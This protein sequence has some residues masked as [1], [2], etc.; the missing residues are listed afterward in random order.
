MTAAPS[1]KITL[2]SKKVNKKKGTAVVSA[3]VPGPGQ[4]TLTDTRPAATTSAV[5]P[6][7]LTRTAAGSFNVPIKPKGATAKKL[8]KKGKAGVKAFINFT[9]A[10][11]AGVTST[12]PVKLT[13]VKQRPKKKK[14]K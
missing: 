14:K 5:K 12:Q 1:N 6:V 2:G 8:K 3:K 9:P 7:G 10:G 11:V 13:L 4:V